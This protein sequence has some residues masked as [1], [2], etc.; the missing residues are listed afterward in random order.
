MAFPDITQLPDAPNR[1][2]DSS[3]EFSDNT[4]AFLNA[5]IDFGDQVNEA[6]EYLDSLADDVESSASEAAVSA[7]DAAASEV[8]AE[9]YASAA[10]GSTNWQRD[11]EDG[12]SGT[13]GQSFSYLNNFIYLLKV[14]LADISTSEPSPSNDDWQLIS[15]VDYTPAE[16]ALIN[17]DFTTETYNI[18][19][20]FGAGFAQKPLADI[21]THTR[22]TDATGIAA[23]LSLG[24][25]GANVPR[26][27]YDPETGEALGYQSEESRTNLVLESEDFSGSSWSGGTPVIGAY[28]TLN[29]HRIC[30][31]TDDSDSASESRR[32]DFS[33]LSVSTSYTISFIAKYEDAEECLIT[34]QGEAINVATIAITWNSDGSLNS[35]TSGTRYTNLGAGLYKF[36]STTTTSPTTGTVGLYFWP[37]GFQSGGTAVGTTYFGEPQLEVGAF[38]TSYIPTETASTVTR[39][40]DRMSLAVGDNLN[41]S[42]F[43]LYWEGSFPDGFTTGSGTNSVILGLTDNSYDNGFCISGSSGNDN[44]RVHIRSGGSGLVLRNGVVDVSGNYKFLMSFNYE[45][46]T[47]KFYSNGVLE[48]SSSGSVADVLDFSLLDTMEIAQG[49]IGS[50]FGQI[51]TKKAKLLNKAPSDA[52]AIRMTI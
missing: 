40:A 39:A 9:L 23:N 28:E 7:S 51:F 52:D 4:D 38:S 22:S 2:T 13:A 16:T 27:V 12:G 42:S 3:T 17:L 44:I 1:Q 35:V 31:I 10:A 30:P 46:N 5:L 15:T 34:L 19:E 50:S 14:D 47:V 25:A 24:T 26:L 33:G 43:S 21:V 41:Q 6:G 45:T 48:D 20:G 49:W 8:N 32:Q 11:W 18:Y 37:A 36:S 29:G